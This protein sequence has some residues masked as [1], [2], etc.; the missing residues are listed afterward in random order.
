MAANVAA[1]VPGQREISF[2]CPRCG[3]EERV[4]APTIR[5]NDAKTAPPWTPEEEV[6]R[7][8]KAAYP[9]DREK[10]TR[11]RSAARQLA[12]DRKDRYRTEI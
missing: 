1:I 12:I 5:Q 9:A 4:K 11:Q 3:K 7:C 2:G 8:W 10:F 6:D